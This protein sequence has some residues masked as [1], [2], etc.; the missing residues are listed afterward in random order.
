MALLGSFTCPFP[1]FLLLFQ[2]TLSLNH[3]HKTLHLRLCFLRPPGSK[4]CGKSRCPRQGVEL[5][6]FVLPLL[7]CW[8]LNQSLMH[9]GQWYG[10]NE[11]VLALRTHLERLLVYPRLHSSSSIALVSKGRQEAPSSRV[12]R[13]GCCKQGLT[14]GSQ[15]WFT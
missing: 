14:K 3:L 12:E 7:G 15:F 2:I 8:V 4:M 13:T 5:K 6:S 9:L 10:A 1:V 11:Q